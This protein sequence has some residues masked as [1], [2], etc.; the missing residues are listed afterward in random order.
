VVALGRLPASFVDLFGHANSTEEL[1]ALQVRVTNHGRSN[2]ILNEHMQLELFDTR[3]AAFSPQMILDEEEDRAVQYVQRRVVESYAR[4]DLNPG[5]LRRGQWRSDLPPGKSTESLVFFLVPYD[6]EGLELDFDPLLYNRHVIVPI[7]STANVMHALEEFAEAARRLLAE[8]EQKEREAQERALQAEQAAT[9]LATVETQLVGADFEGA[10]ET[11]GQLSGLSWEKERAEPCRVHVAL[12]ELSVASTQPYPRFV[13][14]QY[15]SGQ[16]ALLGADAPRAQQ[17]CTGTFTAA[18]RE[19]LAAGQFVE[20]DQAWAQLN[21]F[22]NSTPETSALRVEIHARHGEYACLQGDVAATATQLVLLSETQV[23]TYPWSAPAAIAACLVERGQWL[24]S[25]SRPNKARAVHTR[26]EA[27][28]TSAA[29][30]KLG[31]DIEAFERVASRTA[32]MDSKEG[33][34][35]AALGFWV[36]MFSGYGTAIGGGMLLAGVD[37]GVFSDDAREPMT[38]LGIGLIIG[39]ATMGVIG[40]A[41]WVHRS[42]THAG[43]GREQGVNFG[44]AFSPSYIEARWTW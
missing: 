19:Y 36:L 12:T 44:L 41:S 32:H 29:S 35:E 33:T 11:C 14:C 21:T 30:K 17:Y 9:L 5:G 7:G 27:I 2:L 25:D 6:S 15:L 40:V 8:K 22:T 13:A 20:A 10:R 4:Y 16:Y 43:M 38:G 34:Q 1:L 24:L 37:K 23:G 18:I 31:R 28:E 3:G 42:K 39:G 26:A